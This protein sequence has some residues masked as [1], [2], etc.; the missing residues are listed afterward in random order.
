MRG[1]DRLKKVVQPA[2]STKRAVRSIIEFPKGSKEDNMQ[3]NKKTPLLHVDDLSIGFLNGKR[4]TKAVDEI[5]FSLNEGE[6]VGIVGESGSG[7]SVTALSIIGL[8]AMDGS[9]LNGTITYNEKILNHLP[10]REMRKYRGNE[11]AMVFQEPMTS[12]NPVITIGNQLEEMLILHAKQS[13]EERKQN[14]LE[15]LKEVGLHQGESLLNKYPHELSGGMRQRVMIAMA[16]L[17]RPK[18][19]IADEPTTALDVTIQA[20]ILSLLKKMNEK[21]GTSILLISHNL[22]VVKNICSRAIVMHEGKIEEIGTMQELFETP[23]KEYTKRLLQASNQEM[24]PIKEGRE[25]SK[26]NIVSVKDLQVF[27]NKKKET[28]FGKSEKV[29]VVKKVSF[30]M[31]QGEILGIVGESGCGKSTLAKA[32]VGLQDMVKGTME[33]GTKYPQMVFQ[34]PYS[35]LN[36]SKKI[37]WL[38]EEPLRFHKKVSERERKELVLEMLKK[39]GLP[40]EFANRFPSELSGGQRQRVA[41]AMAIILNQELIVLDEPVSALDVTVQAQI[42]EL[43]LQLQSE[44]HLSYLF[45]SHDMSVIR[46][47]CDRVLVM[48]QGEIV[49]LG[50]T[51]EIFN[52]PKQEYTKKLIDAIL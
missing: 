31:K 14:I 38:L 8:L 47:L 28:L 19:L 7:K 39:V 45:I 4:F 48:Y 34:D 30:D 9:I 27:Y 33:I 36:P 15:M 37:G 24:K 26:T 25:I 35:S 21:H 6:I 42:L 10:E 40:I 32:I 29:E 13:K 51:E 23:K 12:L 3:E 20:K 1:G 2:K 22:N 16:M 50:N 46:K 18:L 49:E 43:L 41:I 5:S 52:R 11:I 44:Y 17:M